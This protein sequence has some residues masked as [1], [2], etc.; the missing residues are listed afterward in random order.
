MVGSATARFRR[1][2]VL[3]G[4][5]WWK[6]SGVGRFL[7]DAS[8]GATAIVAGAVTVMAVGASALIVDHNWL[9]DQRDVLKSASDAA[10]VAATIELKRL[11][12]ETTDETVQTTLQQI[13]QT[14]VSLNLTYLPEE[15]LT[16]A[17]E[18][19][20]VEVTPDRAQSTVDVASS[21]DLVWCPG[22]I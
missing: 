21:A 17:K 3:A 14:Y 22:D 4:T 5:R 20:T 11:P 12:P 16:R 10:A 19:L 18:T 7:R 13:A 6:R 9:V 8:G 15:R 2:S 1:A